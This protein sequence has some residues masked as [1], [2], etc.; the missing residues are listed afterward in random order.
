[1]KITVRYNFLWIDKNEN[2]SPS[3]MWEQELF[4]RSW[5]RHSAASCTDEDEPPATLFCTYILGDNLMCAQRD[6]ESGSI[7]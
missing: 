6:L 1:M 5:Y 4:T 3:G 2:G 7:L